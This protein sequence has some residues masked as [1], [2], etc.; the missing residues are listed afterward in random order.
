[1]AYHCLTDSRDAGSCRKLRGRVL[2]YLVF[3]NEPGLSWTGTERS[4]VQSYLDRTTRYLTYCARRDHQVLTA[5]SVSTQLTMKAP[6]ECEEKAKWREGFAKAKGFS[7]MSALCESLKKSHN[8]EAVAFVFATKQKGRSY[9]STAGQGSGFIEALTLYWDHNSETLLHEL[10]HLFGAAD[11]YYP[12]KVKAAAEKYFPNS[13]MLRSANREI[14]ELT[15]YLIGWMDQPT[16]KAQ[17]MLRDT[18]DV[19]KEEVDN[20][21]ARFKAPPKDGEITAL[22]LRFPEED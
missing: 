3:V 15:R 1:M 2:F 20:D 5:T 6:L 13:V 22:L 17:A 14:D 11:Y 12:P 9:A 10:L 18:A 8:T 19:T 4:R 21:P 16:P 7:G